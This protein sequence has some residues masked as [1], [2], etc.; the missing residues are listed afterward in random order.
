[1]KVIITESQYKKILLEQ[2]NVYTD[3]AKYK[4]T[5]LEQ[6][7]SN[8]NCKVLV[9]SKDDPKYKKYLI[10]NYVYW[11][12]RN[13]AKKS[14]F[15]GGIYKDNEYDYYSTEF[16]VDKPWFAFDKIKDEWFKE[17]NSDPKIEK[18]KQ[19]CRKLFLNNIRLYGIK[20]K[21]LGLRDEMVV[22]Y[23]KPNKVCI[24]STPDTP[25]KQEPP[26]VN[27]PVAPTKPSTPPT[28]TSTLDKTK[29]V[30]FYFGNRIF[31]APDYETAHRFAEKLAI[32]NLNSNQVFVYKDKNNEKW[33]IGANDKIYFSEDLY[34][35]DPNKNVYVDP[36]KMGMAVI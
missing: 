35:Q 18:Y 10:E 14:P 3:E 17:K 11:T 9:N 36:V 24:K 27:K 33:F 29:P 34:N 32:R 1:M 6:T 26:K 31:R 8:K 19:E 15:F 7:S 5:L 28:P 4:K 23:K 21:S 13:L 25:T 22:A 20:P 30:D 2:S 16:I 12:G